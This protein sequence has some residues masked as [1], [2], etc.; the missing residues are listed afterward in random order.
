MSEDISTTNN[1]S[2]IAREAIVSKMVSP[3]RG[4]VIPDLKSRR[5]K[6]KAADVEQAFRD[7]AAQVDDYQTTVT[8]EIVQLLALLITEVHRETTSQR[9]VAEA[10]I[11]ELREEIQREGALIIS[12]A[13][14][15]ALTLDHKMEEIRRIAAEVTNVANGTTAS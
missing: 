12:N 10:E 9:Q 7:I 15:E 8:Q 4:I 13:Q 1:T 11:A 14:R 5:R 6:Y 3:Q 2:E